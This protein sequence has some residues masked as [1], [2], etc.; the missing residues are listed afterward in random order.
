MF[1]P[2]IVPIVSADNFFLF[3]LTAAEV[4][5]RKAH[6]YRPADHLDGE[7]CEVL[8]LV[9]SGFFSRGDPQVFRPLL[10]GL[11]HHDPYLVLADFASYSDCQQ[12]VSAAYRDLERWTRM[13]I[14]NTA[15]SGKFSSDRTIREYCGDIW[16]APAV[17]VRLLSQQDVKSGFM[18]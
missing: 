3:G 12:Q 1:A 8:D 13:S 6:G 17:P 10:D 9:G 15:R 5:E 16:K 2:S 11:I 18:Q 14:L 7:M 4:A